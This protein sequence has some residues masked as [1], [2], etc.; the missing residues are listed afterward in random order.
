MTTKKA[1]RVLEHPPA[2][3]PVPSTWKNGAT[4]M[5]P[6]QSD[7]APTITPCPV[8]WCPSAGRHQWLVTGPIG[9]HRFHT[10]EETLGAATSTDE[11]VP[12][13]IAASVFE[14]ENGKQPCVQISVG[15]DEDTSE[16]YS[17]EAVGKVIDAIQHASDLAFG[18]EA[19]SPEQAEFDAAVAEVTVRAGNPTDVNRLVA[20]AIRLRVAFG[21]LVNTESDA[22]Q[23]DEQVGIDDVLHAAQELANGRAGQ[24]AVIEAWERLGRLLSEAAMRARPCPFYWC[25]GCEWEAD[26][27]GGALSRHHNR[28]WPSGVNCGVVEFPDRW[29]EPQVTIPEPPGGNM[30][31]VTDLDWLFAVSTDL[32]V[33]TAS[34]RDAADLIRTRLTVTS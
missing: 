4:P 5:I 18:F 6:Q 27:V 13:T 1:G 33:A 19:S 24:N 26:V 14:T 10:V 8:D 2:S 28:Y 20:A 3:T 23:V 31:E 29:D 22:D 16:F 7:K 17:P 21:A 34:V 12:V 30:D 32:V 25:G 9:G 11:F 15:T